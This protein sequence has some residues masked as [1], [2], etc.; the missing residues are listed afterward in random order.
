MG[1]WCPAGANPPQSAAC[2]DGKWEKALCILQNPWSQGGR[3][4]WSK[5]HL[6]GLWKPG[7]AT[8]AAPS[9]SQGKVSRRL[10]WG[11][12]F[13][14]GL[15]D[16]RKPENCGQSEKP[17]DNFPSQSVKPCFLLFC[18]NFSASLWPLQSIHNEYLRK[19]NSN[20]PLATK[21]SPGLPLSRDSGVCSAGNVLQLPPLHILVGS[22]H[23][24]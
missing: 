1:S 9:R 11:Q 19:H 2:N 22:V 14:H 17:E 5:A 3:D 10:G 7:E 16:G 6:Q 15:G 23:H 12:A 24:L 21:S 8:P 4:A 18:A 13:S 20:S